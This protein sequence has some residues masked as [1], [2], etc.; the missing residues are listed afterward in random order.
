MILSGNLGAAAK[1][2]HLWIWVLQMP[3]ANSPT[4]VLHTIRTNIQHAIIVAKKVISHTIIILKHKIINFQDLYSPNISHNH[5][6]IINIMPKGDY[7]VLVAHQA[8]VGVT[9]TISVFRITGM[10]PHHHIIQDLQYNTCVCLQQVPRGV[11][12][13][14]TPD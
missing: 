10:S 2:M 14:H 3:N 6:C 7:K 1:G 11:H 12:L 13:H 4:T 8:H 5:Y 9:I